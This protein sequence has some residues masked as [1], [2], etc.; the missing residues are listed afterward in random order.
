MLHNMNVCI[1]ILKSRNISVRNFSVIYSF[2]LDLGALQLDSHVEM[3]IVSISLKNATVMMIV[4][5]TAMKKTNVLVWWLLN[6]SLNK[7]K[8]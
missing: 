1:I 6:S 3:G 7:V 2:Q 5:T 4:E 8:F